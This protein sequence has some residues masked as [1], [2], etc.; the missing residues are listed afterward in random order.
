M[1]TISIDHS[2]R[3]YGVGVLL[4]ILMLG[5]SLFIMLGAA[6]G[7]LSFQLMGVRSPELALLV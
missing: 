6:F 1:E 7:G 5:A 4:A 3:D 2:R